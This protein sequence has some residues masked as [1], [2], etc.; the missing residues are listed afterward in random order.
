MRTF[1][2][3]PPSPRTGRHYGAH[4]DSATYFDIFA[5]DAAAATLR[6]QLI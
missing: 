2:Q 5:S 1:Y 4:A 6:E 3:R